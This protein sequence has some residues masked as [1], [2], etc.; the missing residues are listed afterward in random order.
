M[1]EDAPTKRDFRQ[2]V[3]D[4]IIAMLEK[5]TAPWQKPWD[6]DKAFAL[7]HNPTTNK[8]YRGGN[9][10]HLM[11]A[12]VRRGFEDPRWLTFRQA[13]E[14]GWHVKKGEK[15]THIEF[16]QFPDHT[17]PDT[18]ATND[19]EAAHTRDPRTPI[20]RVY[21]VFNA[22]QIEG[23]PAHQP[24]QT[25]AWEAVQ[26]AEQI[27]ANSGADLHHDQRDRAFYSRTSDSIHL[28]PHRAFANPADYYG[29]A[30]HELAH[31]AETRTMPH[32]FKTV[33]LAA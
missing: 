30:L 18:D 10:L 13:E 3:T 27:L 7:P 5:G 25:P 24:R 29:T 22:Q 2:E 14:N 16:W 26:A 31:N 11:A 8:A 21:T 6:P 9:A 1:P 15:G 33:R 19:R 12:G 32:G 28:P 20:H 4:S 17:Q 23:I